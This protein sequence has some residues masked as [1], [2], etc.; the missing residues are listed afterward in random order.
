MHKQINTCS[1]VDGKKGVNFGV[2]IMLFLNEFR[3]LLYAIIDN[4]LF[5]IGYVNSVN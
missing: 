4:S 1:L 2:K 5:V 3:K